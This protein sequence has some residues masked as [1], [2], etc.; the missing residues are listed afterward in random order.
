MARDRVQAEFGVT[1]E[2]EVKLI[3]TDGRYL[4]DEAGHG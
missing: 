2:A 4:N 3:G 1:L